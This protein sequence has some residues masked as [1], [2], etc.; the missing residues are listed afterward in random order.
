M[1][2]TAI[3]TGYAMPYIDFDATIHSVFHT[4]VTHP[5]YHRVCAVSPVKANLGGDRI[6]PG[7]SFGYRSHEPLAI[8]RRKKRPWKTMRNEYRS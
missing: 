1:H 6:S 5:W 4:A 8:L 7:D 2:L 3:F